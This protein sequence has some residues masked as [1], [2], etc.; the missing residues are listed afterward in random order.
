MTS[1]R[2]RIQG[3]HAAEKPARD[4]GDHV[5][6]EPGADGPG[7]REWLDRAP[8]ARPGNRAAAFD[9]RLPSALAGGAARPIARQLHRHGYQLAAKPEGF[10]VTGT[11]G[12]LREGELNRARAW[13]AALATQSAPAPAS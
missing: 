2:S 3:L 10:I 9:T 4:K 13:G 8:L 6:E 5:E 1:K 11:E 12:P 7:A